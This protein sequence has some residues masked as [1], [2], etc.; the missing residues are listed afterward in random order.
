M[1]ALQD[2]RRRRTLPA[3]VQIRRRWGSV[4]GIA[5][6][7]LRGRRISLAPRVHGR[8][9]SVIRRG[10]GRHHAVRM[11]RRWVVRMVVIASPVAVVRR[12]GVPGR[13]MGV[14]LGLLLLVVLFLG[15]VCLVA[16]PPHRGQ[17]QFLELAPPQPISLVLAGLG[18]EGVVQELHLQLGPLRFGFAQD[19]LDLGLLFEGPLP[20]PAVLV[21]AALVVLGDD[22]FLVLGP[23]LPGLGLDGGH[24]GPVLGGPCPGIG[25]LAG[26]AIQDLLRNTD[27]L[28]FDVDLEVADS[29]RFPASARELAPAVTAAGRGRGRL[30]RTTQRLGLDAT[31]LMVVLAGGFFR[32]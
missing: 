28:W 12:G 16:P 17:S 20:G 9:V 6:A 11:G 5:S 10:R 19:A 26:P 21:L 22:F 2:R 30:V 31:G 3:T 13:R 4:V 29:A 24:Q 23:F 25:V 7:A 27:S 18:P 14:C 32:R 1:I 8:G 15:Q